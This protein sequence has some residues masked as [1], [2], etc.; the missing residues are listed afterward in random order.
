MTYAG[1]RGQTAEEMRKVLHFTLP[2]DKLHAAYGA[3]VDD[4]QKDEQTRPFQLYVANALWGQQGYPFLKPFLNIGKRHYRA[5]LEEVDFG[6]TEQARQT[7]NRWVADQTRDK[8]KEL[9]NPTDLSPATRLALTNAIYFKAAWA[10][11][12]RWGETK[13]APFQ[14]SKY[15]TI[16]VPMMQTQ[17]RARFRYLADGDCDWL[18]LPYGDDEHGSRV[19]MIVLLPREGQLAAVEARLSPKAIHGSIAKLAIHSG[20][21]SLP[22]FQVRATTHLKGELSHMGM[23]IAFSGGADF[24]GVTESKEL[25]IGSVIHQAYLNVDEFGSEAAAGTAVLMMRNDP[26]PFSFTAN[27]P[28]LFFIRD[29]STSSPLFQGRVVRP[30]KVS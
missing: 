3:L 29:N 27:R 12:F 6:Q 8:I 1:A 17:Q 14:V 4:L 13:D 10:T 7:I 2:D 19:S 16:T 5:G 23:P 9:L 28:F 21:V 26:P 18:E 30:G 11:P 20:K 22:K 25:R 24:S 15:E